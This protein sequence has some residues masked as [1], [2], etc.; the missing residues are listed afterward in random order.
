MAVCEIGHAPCARLLLERGTDANQ[1]TSYGFTALIAACH[2]GH[3]PC[4]RLLLE[5]GADANL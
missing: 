1:A 2:N 4:T 5:R 3:E